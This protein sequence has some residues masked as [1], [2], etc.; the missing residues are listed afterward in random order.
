MMNKVVKFFLAGIAAMATFSCVEPPVEEV[1]EKGHIELSQTEVIIS[2][3]GETVKVVYQLSGVEDGAVISVENDAD[4]LS[5]STDL[6]RVIEMTASKNDND[7][8]RQTVL[9]VSCP[10]C[11]DV[12]LTVVQPAWE[13]PITL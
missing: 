7:Q 5:V 1:V 3:Y 8:A 9:T 12:D 10:S 6:P 11:D 2:S 13:D 4:W